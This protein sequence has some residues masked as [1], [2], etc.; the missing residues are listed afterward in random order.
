MIYGAIVRDGSPDKEASENERRNMRERRV[1]RFVTDPEK[2]CRAKPIGSIAEALFVAR[3]E[4]GMHVVTKA[5]FIL[6]TG[7][8]RWRAGAVTTTYDQLPPEYRITLHQGLSVTACFCPASGTLLG[9]DVHERGRN[10]PEDAVLDLASFE[11]L[12]QGEALR[13]R[14]PVVH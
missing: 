13:Q 7:D 5:G 1:G 9:L 10:P 12:W 8:T 3:D 2:F 14:K 11:K 6:A 4:R